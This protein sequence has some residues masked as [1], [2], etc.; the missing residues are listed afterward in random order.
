MIRAYSGPLSTI[1]GIIITVLALVTN[2]PLL[3]LAVAT[4]WLSV[5]AVLASPQAMTQRQ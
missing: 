3:D 5:P 4:A 2:L 1:A